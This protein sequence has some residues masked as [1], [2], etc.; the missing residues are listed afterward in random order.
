M[1]KPLQKFKNRMFED[2]IDL[3]VEWVHNKN[4]SV[5]FDYCVQ[6]EFRPVEK[7][8]TVN[9]RQ[10]KEKQLYALLHECGH[11][12]LGNNEKLYA[13]KYPSSAKM[14]YFNSN[15][16]LENSHKYK[17]DVLAEEI[18]AWR[19]GKDLANRLGIYIEEENY[20]NIM[21]K[22][23]YSYIKDLGK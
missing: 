17:V 8:I 2:G 15:R 13:K 22:C 16:K 4:Y 6:D 14:A 5:D 10:G 23:V 7:L 18:D 21:S 1:D 9:T 3:V 19:K 20:Y 11:L 12:I